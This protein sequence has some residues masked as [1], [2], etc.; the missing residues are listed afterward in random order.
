[1]KILYC[2]IITQPQIFND[3]FEITKSMPFAQ[4]KLEEMIIDGFVENGI[5]DDIEILSTM[6]VQ[7]YP[8]YPKAIINKK[9]GNNFG[10]KTTYLGFVNLPIIKQF[11]VF[12]SNLSQMSKWARRNKKQEKT[13]LIYGTNPLNTIPAMIVRLFTKTKITAYVTEID[14]LRVFKNNNIIDKIKKAMFVSFS[15]ITENHFDSYILIAEQMKERINKKQKPTCVIEGMV[16]LKTEIINDNNSAKDKSI[17]YAGSLHKKYGIS[18]LVDG[19]MQAKLVDYKLIIYGDGDYKPEL[20][21]IASDNPHI[22]YRGLAL[23][24]TILAQERKCSL[25]VNPRPSSEELT[26]YSFPSK[27]FEYMLSGTPC[28][29]TKL[30][31]IPSE[32]FNYCFTIEDETVE[33]FSSSIKRVLLDNTIEA[34]LFISNKAKNY[35]LE[36]KSN[37]SQTKK[38]IDFINK[39]KEGSYENS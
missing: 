2:G 11:S 5:S 39:N 20:E 17:M 10:V 14:S 34:R 27:T 6:P 19:F 24:E 15:K 26:K 38:I 4:Q 31:G 12:V 33:G 13:I 21:K 18:K 28:L 23:N 16:K 22:E 36:N 29:I 3:I 9:V 32:Y 37:V 35:L 7:R 1:V 8:H 25:L 30:S